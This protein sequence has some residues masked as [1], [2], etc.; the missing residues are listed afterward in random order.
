MNNFPLH[1][2]L[3]KFSLPGV[4]VVVFNI[5]NNKSECDTAVVEAIIMTLSMKASRTCEMEQ[6]DIAH[7]HEL[8]INQIIGKF[9]ANG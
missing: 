9:E 5:I 6:I 2:A 7:G 4:T 1:G 3:W 8:I